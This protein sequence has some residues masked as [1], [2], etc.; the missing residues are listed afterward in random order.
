MAFERRR[1]E[2]VAS[3]I[4]RLNQRCNTKDVGRS[5]LDRVDIAAA[6]SFDD[7]LTQSEA[8]RERSVRRARR[9]HTAW[10]SAACRRLEFSRHTGLGP[11]LCAVVLTSA[12]FGQTGGKAGARYVSA[13]GVRDP[14]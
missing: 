12:V 2:N 3:S 1:L 7:L 6:R 9:A 5:E 13:V 8:R 4:V 10:P 14:S 11:M